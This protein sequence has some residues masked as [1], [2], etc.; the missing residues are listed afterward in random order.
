MLASDSTDS[1]SIPGQFILDY[2]RTQ[3]PVACLLRVLRFPHTDITSFSEEARRASKLSK[4]WSSN[5]SRILPRHLARLRT[6]GKLRI[7]I[8]G[9]IQAPRCN[10]HTEMLSLKPQNKELNFLLPNFD[11]V[12]S[13]ASVTHSG[14]A[15]FES[16]PGPGHPTTLEA[17]RGCTHSL[18]ASAGTV[19]L[20]RPRQLFSTF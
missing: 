9:M 13:T 7:V 11:T 20:S 19:H 18:Q 15:R 14:D 6:A 12:G 3:S 8:Y 4:P 2:L 5:W 17:F 10:K 1:G 16:K